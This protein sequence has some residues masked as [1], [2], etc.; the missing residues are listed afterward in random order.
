MS[1]VTYEVSV[2]TRPE[3]P[4]AVVHE[5]VSRDDLSAFLG[6]A[7]GEVGVVLAQQNMFPT[8]PPLARYRLE[9][10]GFDVEAGFPVPGPVTPTGRVVP[11]TLP[12]GEIAETVHVGPYDA[13]SAAY[14]AVTA[15]LEAE[16]R[17]PTGAP[18]ELY[19][20]APDAPAPRTV[21]C[22]PCSASAG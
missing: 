9:P 12:G 16:G 14:T 7:F 1:T 22:F 10:G 8:G 2:E 11:T 4:A 15:W 17:E 18:W 13:I 5:V 20:D 19:L 21:V 3:Q 6:A